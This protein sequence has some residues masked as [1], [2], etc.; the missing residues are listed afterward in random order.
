MAHTTAPSFWTPTWLSTHRRLRISMYPTAEEK[1]EKKE[2]YL[3][4]K[5]Q[6]QKLVEDTRKNNIE[7]L[8]NWLENNLSKYDPEYHPKKSHSTTFLDDNSIQQLRSRVYKKFKISFPEMAIDKNQIAYLLDIMDE[9]DKMERLARYR[10]ERKLEE[11]KSAERSIREEKRRKE[12]RLKIKEW[13][14]WYQ[15][16]LEITLEPRTF[17]TE[18]SAKK[19][20]KRDL[21]KMEKM[22]FFRYIFGRFDSLSEFSNL[23]EDMLIHLYR[24]KVAENKIND[25]KVEMEKVLKFIEKEKKIEETC[26]ILGVNYNKYT[27]LPGKRW[28]KSKKWTEWSEEDSIRK[29]NN[30]ENIREAQRNLEWNK[31]SIDE[32]KEVIDFHKEWK[33]LESEHLKSLPDPQPRYRPVMNQPEVIY[34]DTGHCLTIDPKWSAEKRREEIESFKQAV[35]DF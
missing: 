5:L 32:K 13:K 22:Y 6:E 26:L 30:N 11:K 24:V 14:K 17:K 4:K 35:R 8:N 29:K 20:R 15:S 34:T 21:G 31:L 2:Q 7:K 27:K 16:A 12:E 3:Q 28:T 1:A 19:A 18:L 25:K 10:E 33:R 9:E 23:P